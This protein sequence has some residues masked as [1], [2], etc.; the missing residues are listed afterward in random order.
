M[1]PAPRIRRLSCALFATALSGGWPAAAGAFDIQSAATVGEYY[2]SNVA[3]AAD[4][5][6]EDEWVTALQPEIIVSNTGAR[7]DLNL[8]YT[9]EL[10]YFADDSNWEFFNRLSS[11]AIL[12]L[13][14]E[15]LYLDADAAMF[16]SN[17]DPDRPL[18][19]SN[20]Y[21]ATGNRTDG[22]RWQVGPRWEQPL[23][24]QSEATAY[25][26][27][28]R[29][30]YDQPDDPDLVVEDEDWVT[31]GFR[32]GDR[33]EAAGTAGYELAYQ[34]DEIEYE[35]SDKVKWASAHLQLIGRLPSDL[36]V[37]LL[38]GLESDIREPDSASLDEGRWEIGLAADLADDQLSAG[39]GHRYFGTTYRFSWRRE[40]DDRSYWASYDETPSTTDYRSLRDLATPG[41]PSGIPPPPDSG[42][43][44]PGTGDVSIVKRFDLG[45][46]WTRYRSSLTWSVFWED[47][48]DEVVLTPDTPDEPSA[49]ETALGTVIDFTW[50]IGVRT[51]GTLGASWTHRDF[52]TG[53]DDSYEVSAGLTHDVGVRTSVGFGLGWQTRDL[54]G[55]ADYDEYWARVELTRRFRG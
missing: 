33:P 12:R 49:D 46:A 11:A 36:Q 47:R 25:Y 14:A 35:L 9:P 44:Q 42:L 50:N 19:N 55:T 10:L 41:E 3:L 29:L 16:Q 37:S 31:G 26:R 40:Q 22:T 24:G 30:D 8:T 34:Y 54:G 23:F 53:E 2:S 20:V 51:D 5:Q 17:V 32:L 18:A 6:E 39:L 15:Q 1:H 28:G 4:G 38:G 45:T 52:D 27:V 13:F 7:L 21:D 43:E 48:E